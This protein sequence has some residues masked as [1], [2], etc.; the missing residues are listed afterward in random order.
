MK[1]HAFVAMPFG[2]KPGYNDEIIDCD[3]IYHYLIKPAI[4]AA[5]LEAFRADEE[6]AAGDIKA[7][8]FQELLIADLVVVDLTLDNPNVWYEL[9]IRHALRARGVVLVQ[10]P[11]PTQPFDIYTDRKCRYQLKDGV[12]DPASKE[13]DKNKLVEIIK[14][15]M[16]SWHGRKISPVYQLLS[17]LQEP[18]WKALSVSAAQ[19]FWQLHNAW[20]DRIKLAQKSNLIGDLLVLAEEAPVAA[21]RA[22]AKIKAGIAL[23]KAERFQF[24][25]EQL[26]QGLAVDHNNLAGSREKGICLNRLAVQG[27]TGHSQERAKQ[28]YQ[29]IL[30]TFPN[31]PETWALLGRVDKEAW[32]ATW[33]DPALSSLQKREEAAYEDALL[34]M[35]IESYRQGFRRNPGHYFSGI[36]ALTLMHLYFDL[37]KDNRF[38]HE[39]VSMAGAVRFGAEYETDDRQR[40]WAKAT[41]GDLEVLAGNPDSVT[42]A[43]KEAVACAENDLFALNSTLMQLRLLSSLDF[44]RECVS[45]GIAVLERALS[46]LN[47]PETQWQPRQVLLFSGHMID[48]PE[49]ETTRFPADKES[50]AAGKIAE[51]LDKLEANEND[52]ALCQAACGGDILFIEACQQRKVKV[53]LLLPFAEPDFIQRS[54]LP[55]HDGQGWLE[56]YHSLKKNLDRPPRIAPDELGKTPHWVNAYERCNLWLLYT[57]LSYGISRVQF[58]CLWNGGGADG[59]GGTAH[60]YNEVKQRTGQVHWLDTR[61]LW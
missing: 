19:E 27:K 16:E 13:Q 35:A 57:A 11:R 41:L 9:G 26:E 28:H 17:N 60:M 54:I 45:A 29:E 7:D 30:K 31:D 52:L 23:R 48:A 49:R 3:S 36:N 39:T 44:R 59:P 4:E 53:Q 10:G 61:K 33:N 20:E 47:K 50:I 58:I 15:T 14:A 12:P 34:R 37:T 6:L 38:A 43:Y 46:R 55:C 51:A 1:P 22:E 42:A 8:M 56:R 21:F 18:E 24:A 40:F 5:G 32:T 2:K 25:L